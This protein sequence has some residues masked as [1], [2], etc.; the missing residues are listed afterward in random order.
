MEL[1]KGDLAMITKYLSRYADDILKQSLASSGAVWIQGPKWCGKTRTASMQSKSVLLMQ[2]PDETQNYIQMA[3]IKPSL[4]LSGETPRLIDEWQMAPVI[5]DAVR[6]AVDQRGE[7]GQFI[8]TGSTLPLNNEVMHSGTGRISRMLMRTMSLFE[9]GESNGQVSL[10]NLFDGINPEGTSAL[11]VQELAYLI[12]RG[13]WPGALGMTDRNALRQVEN[14]LD[15][16][17]EHDISEVDGVS[18]DPIRARMVMRS[19]A[20]NIAS[21]ASLPVI[22]SDVDGNNKPPSSNTVAAYLNG[23]ERLF[24]IENQPAWSPALRSRSILRKTAKRHFIDPSIAVAALKTNPDGILKD[25]NTFGYLFESLC[26]RDLRIYTQ[27]L[28]GNV[29][30]YQDNTGLEADAIIALHDGR[31]GAVEVKMGQ[32]KV[33]EAAE[34]LLKLKAKVDEDKVNPPSFLMV[35]TGSGYAYRRKDGVF[36]VPIG[37]LKA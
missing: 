11:E 9:S 33:D 12:A 31:W 6:Y 22:Q 32:K 35:L 10:A 17:V 7:T 5:W 28:N 20:R 2:D 18:R 25:F 27:V 14:Y 37:C 3:D 4:L 36:C 24:V 29:L 13:G 19:L 16:I 8:L 21:T 23:L 26:V 34:N 1:M 15:A 30:H